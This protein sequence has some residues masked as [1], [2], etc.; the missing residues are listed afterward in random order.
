MTTLR[1]EI[2]KTCKGHIPGV[3]VCHHLLREKGLRIDIKRLRRLMRTNG[4]LHRFHRKYVQT[5]DSNHNLKKSPNL[6]ERRFDQFGINQ[7]WCGDITYIPTGEG[8]LYLASV[9]DLGTRR[10]VGYSFGTQMTKQLVIAALSMAY[11]NEM[12]SP[13]CIFHSDQGS[14]YCSAAFQESLIEHHMIS[15][16]SH[17]GQCWDNAPAESFWATLKRETLPMFGSFSSRVEAQ[18]KVQD[19]IYYY[20]GRRPHSKLGMKSPNSYYAQLLKAI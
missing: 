12:P 1:S 19:W 17:R 14:Q 8:W 3:L 10:L 18:K 9:L 7:A 4:L 11:E 5:T 16:M 13:G 20:N 2:L 6:I 15:S